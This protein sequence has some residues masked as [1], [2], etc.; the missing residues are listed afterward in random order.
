MAAVAPDLAVQQQEIANRELLAKML[1]AQG[2]QQN[3]AQNP[4]PTG[5]ALGSIGDALREGIGMWTLLKSQGDQTDLVRQQVE[6]QNRLLQEGFGSQSTAP[7]PL[8]V[9]T[10]AD[11]STPT[12]DYT[13]MSGPVGQSPLFQPQKQPGPAVIPGMEPRRALLANLLWPQ[14]YGEAYMSNYRQPDRIRELIAE[15]IDP[16]TVAGYTL[17]ELQAKGTQSWAPNTTVMMPGQSPFVTPSAAPAGGMTVM[18]AQGP[19]V[20]A[21]PGA[22]AVNAGYTGPEEEA[23]QQARSRNTMVNTIGADGRPVATR[24]SEAYGRP[25]DL[26]LEEKA[27]I[28]ASHDY[29]KVTGANGEDIYIRKTEYP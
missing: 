10:F 3:W 9:P 13:P 1:L 11:S 8:P 7:E 16:K 18:T 21:I 17:A 29:I 12:S 26:S 2:G 23:K 27:T 5:A 14:A 24:Q 25:T 22:A 20:V 28:Q 15:G 4:S 19:Q 6:A